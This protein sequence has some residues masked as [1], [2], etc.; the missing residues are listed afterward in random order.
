MKILS[1]KC[2]ER[3]NK[4]ENCDKIMS[5]RKIN[6]NRKK[7]FKWINQGYSQGQWTECGV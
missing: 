7:V 1:Q 3:H 5:V 2:E 4:G 6:F